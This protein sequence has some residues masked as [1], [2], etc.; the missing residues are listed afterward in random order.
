MIE[1]VIFDVDGTLVDSNKIH[2]EVWQ[3][4]FHHFGKDISAADIH[5]QIGKGGDQLMPVFLSEEELRDKGAAIEEFRAD[6]FKREYLSQVQPFPQVSALFRRIAKDGKRILLG[7]SGK[8][9]ELDIYKGRAGIEELV[10]GM[11]TS[12]DSEKSKPH[13]D[14]FSV[15]SRQPRFSW[16]GTRP[17][18]SRPRQRQASRRSE[19]CAADLRK[20][21]CE[22]R[23]RLPSTLTPRICSHGMIL[24]P[25][26]I[27]YP[28]GP[29]RRSVQ[30]AKL[31]GESTFVALAP[32]AINIH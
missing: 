22:M 10:T 19:C 9:E 17:M 27:P 11:T 21:S 1:A 24:R 6:L 12:D 31:R 7:S 32:P 16:W 8:R 5:H 20:Q 18:T 26:R 29:Q 3:K 15:G 23:E 25:S 30:L 13:P 2:A 14:I 4:A 28:R